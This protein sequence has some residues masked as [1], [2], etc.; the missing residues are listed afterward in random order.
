MSKIAYGCIKKKIEIG[1]IE[2]MN[3]KQR[4]S[5]PEIYYNIV[6]PTITIG[7]STD[8]TMAAAASTRLSSAHRRNT[9]LWYIAKIFETYPEQWISGNSINTKYVGMVF[10]M[11]GQQFGY[12]DA[13]TSEIINDPRFAIPGDVQRQLRTFY[14]T[15]NKNGISFR[16]TGKGKSKE[17][18][19]EPSAEVV[20]L[21]KPKRMFTDEVK[22]IVRERCSNKCE[23][24]GNTEYE[25]C[26]DHWRSY[27][28]YYE[29]YPNI[30]TEGNCVW[31]CET[32][33]IIKKDRSAIHL[34]RKGK[35][36]MDV[37]ET[38]EARITENGFP[39][40]EEE[41]ADNELVRSA[42]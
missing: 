17:Y 12:S 21:T 6:N 27:H 42:L 13:K 31:L 1:F 19:F 22:D 32:C 9:Q 35:C 30:T 41:L 36:S 39:I 14:D 40:S 7:L 24:C 18:Y 26:S 3:S 33:N 37:Y 25:M 34:V 23:C 20:T 8:T 38:I 16:F 11:Q 15:H 10:F 5:T 2:Q 4:S 29:E 28:H